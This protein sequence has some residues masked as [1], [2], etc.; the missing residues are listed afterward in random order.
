MKIDV[1]TTKS[2][3]VCATVVHTH[4]DFKWYYHLTFTPDLTSF[5]V[6]PLF[7]LPKL[8]FSLSVLSPSRLCKVN[9]IFDIIFINYSRMLN[10]C[11]KIDTPR[12]TGMYSSKDEK[13]RGN[14]LFPTE[15]SQDSQCTATRLPPTAH[16]GA[17]LISV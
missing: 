7:L 5:F 15:Y 1:S 12:R 16:S 9:T 8:L 4:T 6:L 3:C 10:N 11:V 14:C 13:L 2:V 17:I